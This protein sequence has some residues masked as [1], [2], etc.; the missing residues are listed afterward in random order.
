MARVYRDQ[1]KVLL[2]RYLSESAF[3][4]KGNT[5]KH[6]KNFY[7]KAKSSIWP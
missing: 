1:L 7:L 5:F 2:E 4:Q 3:E 6:F